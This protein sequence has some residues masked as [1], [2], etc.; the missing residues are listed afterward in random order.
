MEIFYEIISKR[1]ECNSTMVTSNKSFEEWG[2]ILFDPVLASAIL[3]RLVHHCNF[4]VVDGNAESYR[5]RERQG[6][7]RT[8]KRGRPKKENSIDET[9]M[10]DASNED[11]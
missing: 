9:E 6:V 5:M 10:E 7:I 1:Y 11:I 3:D 2:C 4:V 8:G